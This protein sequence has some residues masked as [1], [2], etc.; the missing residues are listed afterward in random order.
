MIK[1]FTD[2]GSFKNALPYASEIFG[3]YQPLLGWKSKRA[4][5]RMTKG[6]VA[7]L[8]ASNHKLTT[9]YSGAYSL[10]LAPRDHHVER[11][12]E[13]KLGHLGASGPRFELAILRAIA[14]RLPA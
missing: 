9:R 2:L 1:S 13:I 7:D 14:S 6:V 12:Q 11:V 3:V 4:L 10:A 8:R 5:H